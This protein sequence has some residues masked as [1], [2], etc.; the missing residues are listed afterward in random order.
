MVGKISGNKCPKKT[1]FC[2]KNSRRQEAK[3]K[4][5]SSAFKN[6]LTALSVAITKTSV[7]SAL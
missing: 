6:V 1:V 5:L 3:V 2:P 4:A 7:V